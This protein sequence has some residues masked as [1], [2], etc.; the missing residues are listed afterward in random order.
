MIDYESDDIS[1]EEM[2]QG[3]VLTSH[4]VTIVIGSTKD[5]LA[6]ASS[7]LKLVEYR[8]STGEV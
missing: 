5:A 6:I 3:C 2:P 1:I 4:G 8:T 7:L